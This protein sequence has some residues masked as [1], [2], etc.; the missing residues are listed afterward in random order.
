MTTLLEKRSILLAVAA[1]VL[2][3]GCQRSPDDVVPLYDSEA[4]DVVDI[5]VSVEASGIIEPVTTVEVKS[6]ASGE[7]LSVH[8]D[9]G[10]V[11]EAGALLVEVDKRTPRNVLAETEATLKA[12]RARRHRPVL[13]APLERSTSAERSPDHHRHSPT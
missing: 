5:Q 8:A 12:A 2:L 9:T 13:A 3:A 6:K 11:V 10:D 4:V 1:A 7:I